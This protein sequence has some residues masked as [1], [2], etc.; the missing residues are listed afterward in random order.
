MKIYIIALILC[1]LSSSATANV[2]QLVTGNDY[3]PY[4]DQSLPNRGMV[5]EIV[6][7]AFKEVGY[8]PKIVFRPWKRAYAETKEGIF[9]GS[10]P[11]IKAEA[12]LK[13]FYFSEPIHTMSIR[14]FVGT[15]SP[16][17]ELDDIQGKRI[18][19]PLGYA[20]SKKFREIIGNHIDQQEAN[21][22]DL[23]SCLRMIRSGRKDF[24]IINEINGWMMIQK[25]FHT[26][27]YCGVR[28]SD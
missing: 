14:V 5:T 4:T 23:A 16:I 26:K 7:S 1:S 12:R 22:S 2:V 9:A 20:V 8:D 11:Y 21:P 13:D 19:I 24:F 27:K 10:F 28:F 25:T 3:H 17:R 15:D 18:C 6:E